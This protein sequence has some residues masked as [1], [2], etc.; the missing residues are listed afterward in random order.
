MEKNKTKDYYKKKRKNKEPVN[1]TMPHFRKNMISDICRQKK[2]DKPMKEK[3]Y[4]L[5]GFSLNLT[6]FEV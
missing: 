4:N 5:Q 1:L 3:A 2:Y 6:L